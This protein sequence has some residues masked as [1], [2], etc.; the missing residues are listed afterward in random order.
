MKLNIQILQGIG[1]T[2]LRRGDILLPQISQ[3]IWECTSKMGPKI[4]R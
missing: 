2:D 4:G 3:F 1:A